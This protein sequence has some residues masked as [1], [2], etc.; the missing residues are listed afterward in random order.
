LAQI[1]GLT[2]DALAPPKGIFITLV[3][4]VIKLASLQQTERKEKFTPFQRAQREPPKAAAQ[5]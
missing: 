1:L 5:S 3:F 4:Q 2:A